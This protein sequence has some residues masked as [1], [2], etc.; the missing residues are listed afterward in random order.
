MCDA[1]GHDKNANGA[2]AILAMQKQIAQIAN[3]DRPIA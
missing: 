1:L 3:A 2:S